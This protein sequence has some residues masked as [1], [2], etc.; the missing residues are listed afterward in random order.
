[1]SVEDRQ[2]QVKVHREALQ[3]AEDEALGEYDAETLLELERD[4]L[5]NALLSG[6]EEK[7]RL[8]S[9]FSPTPTL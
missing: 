8:D 9:V 1:M 3:A 6:M 5:L 2:A 4:P 7:G